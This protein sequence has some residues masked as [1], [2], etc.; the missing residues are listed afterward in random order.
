MTAVTQ[1]ADNEQNIAQTHQYLTFM[2]G[3][4]VYG[5]EILNIREIISYGEITEL[6]MMP[7]FIAGV[8]NLRGS[9]VPI[10]DL[11]Q[12]VLGKPVTASKRT[13]IIIL[14]IKKDGVSIELGIIVDTVQEVLDI[15]TGQI[16]PPVTLGA[17]ID[18]AFISGVAK[19]ND[20]LLILLS[21]VNLL[22]V[23]ELS[24]AGSLPQ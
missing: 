13:S 16:E 12:R 3:S 22:S 24:L 11:S 19:V 4:K 8:I 6:P 10:V 15:E 2:L 17:D 1:T 5:V 14:D 18:S 20:N 9:V 7:E 23:E 21:I